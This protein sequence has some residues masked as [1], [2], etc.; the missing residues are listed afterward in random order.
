VTNTEIFVESVKKSTNLWIGLWALLLLNIL[1]V[2]ILIKGISWILVL[3]II[4]LLG[5][6]GAILLKIAHY[7]PPEP[8]IDDEIQTHLNDLMEEIRPYCEEVFNDRINSFLEPVEHDFQQK[9]SLGLSWL[10]EKVDAFYAQVEQSAQEGRSIFQLID[11]ANEEK[12]K[13]VERLQDNAEQVMAIMKNVQ[14]QRHYDEAEIQTRLQVQIGDFHNSMQREKQYFYEYVYK[15]LLEQARAQGKEMEMV[16]FL[17]PVRLGQQF[18]LVVERSLE[19][20]VS[21]FNNSLLTDLE[22]FSA[23]VVGRFQRSTAKVLNHF[24]DMKSSLQ[25]LID[26]SGNESGVVNR[27]LGEYSLRVNKLEEQAGEILVSLA[28]QDIMVEKRW[29]EVQE[30]LF[31]IKDK[32]IETA[33]EKVLQY[34]EEVLEQVIPGLSAMPRDAGN[35]LLYKTLVDAELIY[36]VYTS[37]KLPEVVSDGVFSLLQ[38]VRALELHAANSIRLTDE[39]LNRLRK[40]KALIKDGSFQALFDRV[41][42]SV[43]YHQPLAAPLIEGVFPGKFQQFV[44]SPYLKNTPDNLNQAAWMVFNSAIDNENLPEENFL[45]VGLLLAVHQIRDRHIQ[46]FNSVPVGMEDP[47]EIHITR[48]AAYQA[49]SIMLQNQ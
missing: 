4:L 19:S 47:E 36:Q 37:N 46:P 9:F 31:T 22:D 45:L 44:N 23:D 34:I 6:G 49:I 38:F 8:G 28:W 5:G 33:D 21:D 11:M 12:L 7:T 43:D 32:V 24:R 1:F 18:G 20:R 29:G 42:M 3:V 14:K 16:E 39:R 40:R 17:S 41:R 10:W 15:M 13:L 30:Q 48:M 25:R 35:A 27:R 2:F 26:M